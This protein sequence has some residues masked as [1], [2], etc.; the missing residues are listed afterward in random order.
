MSS[1]RC[2][3]CGACPSPLELSSTQE[4]G[5]KKYLISHSENCLAKNINEDRHEYFDCLVRPDFDEI[6]MNFCHALSKRSSCRRLQVGCV[7]VSDDRQR[8]LSIGYNGNAAGLHNDCDTDKPGACGCVHSEMNAVAK[9][10]YNDPS[11]KIAFVTDSPCVVC[12][13]MMVN[14]GISSIIYDRKY[15]DSSGLDI[16]SLAGLE[17]RRIKRT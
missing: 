15:R 8:V 6:F 10:N 16:L 17:V 7:I 5:W 2:S 1:V 3:Y 4:Y 13:K 11:K 9:L 14:A 12:A